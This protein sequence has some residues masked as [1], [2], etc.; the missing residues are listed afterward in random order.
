[1][2]DWLMT[3]PIFANRL[4]AG[5]Q[6]SGRLVRFVGADVVVIGL[7]R[8]GVEVAARVAQSLNAS[9][10]VI[11]VRKLGVPFQPELA[12]GAIAEGG[13]QYL[14]REVV[15]NLRVSDEEIDEVERR[16]QRALGER[17]ALVRRHHPAINLTNRDVVIVDDGIATGATARVAC[18]VARV[19]GARRVVLAVPVG[20]RDVV[21]NFV[22]ADEIVYV[23]API[24]FGAVGIYYEDFS[25]TSEKRVLEL[26]DEADLRMKMNGPF[27]DS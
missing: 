8:G 24:S 17:V 1:V 3:R 2:K 4:D 10:D 7:P 13:R 19:R 26:L 11:V 6:L 27:D 18:D 23:T 5:V 16:E 9:L 20:P 12:M 14:D 22:G 25:T 15:R 21:E